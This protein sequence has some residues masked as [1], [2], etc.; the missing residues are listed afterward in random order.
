[1]NEDF[2]ERWHGKNGPHMSKMY[3]LGLIITNS[4][5]ETELNTHAS[6]IG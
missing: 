5:I 3:Q 4:N 2:Q 1:V 6:Y